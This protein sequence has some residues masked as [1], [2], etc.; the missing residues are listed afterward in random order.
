MSHFASALNELMKDKELTQAELAKRSGI[1]Q[2]QI[3][4]WINANP[5]RTGYIADNDFERLCKVFVKPLDQARL[6]RARLFDVCSGPDI[7]GSKLIEINISGEAIHDAPEPHKTK[8]P[9]KLDKDIQTI[10]EHVTTNRLV[11]EMISS[12]AIHLRRKP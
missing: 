4:R 10:I 9:P 6:M 2:P 3:S 7:A 12:L 1:P 11:R 5:I 8:L